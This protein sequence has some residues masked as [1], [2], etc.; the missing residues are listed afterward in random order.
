[1]DPLHVNSGEGPMHIVN[2]I[3]VP[4]PGNEV[5]SQLR[6]TCRGVDVLWPAA[7]LR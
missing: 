5:V 1:M 3:F 6:R 7:L 2:L 4:G